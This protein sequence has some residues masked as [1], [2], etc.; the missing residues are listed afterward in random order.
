VQ[1]IVTT[2]LGLSAYANQTWLSNLIGDSWVANTVLFKLLPGL[3]YANFILRT[4][5]ISSMINLSELSVG[6]QLFI[7]TMN[8]FM[9]FF[10]V[11]MVIFAGVIAMGSIINTAMISLNERER[12]V[13]CLRVLGF[14]NLQVAKIFFGESAILN[15]VG[16]LLGLLGGIYFAY[17]MSTAFSTDMYRMPVVITMRRL[18]EA[19]AVMI[20]FVVLSQAIIYRVIKKLNWFDILNNRE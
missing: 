5:K 11:L 9:T 2:Y 17:Y 13:A 10:V 19:A 3:N 4:N 20:I 1:N 14:T 18:L 7:T 6:K 15:T 12:D 8:Q 16:I